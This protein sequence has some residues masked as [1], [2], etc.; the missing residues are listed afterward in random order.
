MLVPDRDT[1]KELTLLFVEDERLLRKAMGDFLS[2]FFRRVLCAVDAQ[3][4]LALFAREKPDLVLTDIIMPGMDGIALTEELHRRSPETAVVLY[5]AFT[6]VPYLLR[7][8]ELGVAGFVPKPSED[9]KLLSVL[10]KAALPV[11][12]RR[13]LQGL[14]AELSQSLQQMLGHGPAMKTLANQVLRIARTD[15]SLLIQGETGSGKSR[16]ASIVHG[17]SLRASRPLVTVQLGSIPEALIAAELFGHEKGAYTGADRRREGLVSAAHKGTL[18][19]DDIDAAPPSVQALLLRLV[20]EKCYHPLG[21]NRRIDADLRIIAAS[22]RNLAD[23]VAAGRFRQDLYY[24]L[25]GLLVSLPPLR[26]IPGD[27]PDLTAQ[28]LAESCREIGCE[29]FALDAEG[30]AVLAGHPWPGNIRELRNL[31]RRAVVLADPDITPQ[32]LRQLLQPQESSPHDPLPSADPDLPGL[33]LTM[34]AVEQWALQ[35]ALRAAGGKKMQAARLLGMNYYTFRR[36]CAR[37]G[38]EGEE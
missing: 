10:A 24:R 29:P 28:F 16:L 3:E 4:A 7:G 26:S 5:S 25:A 8:I 31:I 20:E 36:R 19:L 12:Q 1:L 23:E 34:D 35:R 30:M 21:S 33:P 18:F 6:E 13:R 9:A 37:F 32:L 2:R 27:L 11:L 17:L 14:E 15:Y 38:L 22:N